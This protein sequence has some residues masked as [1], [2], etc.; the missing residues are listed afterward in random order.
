M[1]IN[2][3]Q[4]MFP[5]LE[6]PP[7]FHGSAMTFWV[8]N[9]RLV[10]LITPDQPYIVISITN[11][12]LVPATVRDNPDLLG[13][14][15][16]QFHDTGDTHQPLRDEVVMTEQEARRILDFVIEYRDRAKVIVCQCEAG[17]SRSAAI[18][19]ALSRWLN[20]DDTFFFA[21]YQPNRRAYHL[22]E[23]AIAAQGETANPA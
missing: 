16:L 19:A 4:E 17:V 13:V 21:N 3:N 10:G 1:S 20:H 7:R 5:L 9:R 15:R 22:M 8:L 2:D 14:L 23:S 11:P 12:G 18:A 6:L